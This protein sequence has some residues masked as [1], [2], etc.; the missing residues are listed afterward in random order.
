MVNH[1]TPAQI[2]AQFP[3]HSDAD[4]IE[5]V[6]SLVGAAGRRQLWLM[7]IDSE[8]RPLPLIVP[9]AG[10]L[11]DTPSEQLAALGGRAC[12]I[13]ELTGAASIVLTWERPGGP[14]PDDTERRMVSA[15]AAGIVGGGVAVRA[16]FLSHS[17]GV[18]RITEKSS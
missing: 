8:N 2:A 4:L 3:L 5:L 14:T 9:I 15:I 6:S 12:E 10:L 13:A 7:F 16:S 11:D 1:T 18:V 17:N